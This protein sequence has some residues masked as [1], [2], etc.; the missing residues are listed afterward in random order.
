MVANSTFASMYWFF[1]DQIKDQI[2]HLIEDEARHCSKVLRK[3]IG[4]HIQV[5]D[6]KG[7]RYTAKIQ[8]IDKREVQA[9]ITKKVTDPPTPYQV[10]LAIAPTKNISRLEW[11]IEKACELGIQSISPILCQRSERK[12]I[13]HDRL[14]KIIMAAVKQSQKAYLPAL[15]PLKSLKEYLKQDLS[16]QKLICHCA[17]ENNTHI[18][19]L[20]NKQSSVH[21]M[22]GPEGDFHEEEVSLALQAGFQSAGLGQQRLRTETAGVY[23]CSIIHTLQEI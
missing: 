7:N 16:G 23:A 6:G 13:K 3:Q 8:S 14:Q 18:A 15:H 2:I 4:D 17:Y 11:C 1:S 12:V 10:H 9:N 5:L 20:Y 22:I 21:I 19:K